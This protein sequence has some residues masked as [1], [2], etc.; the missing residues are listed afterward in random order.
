[1]AR[2]KLAA[3]VPEFLEVEVRRAL[4]GLDAERRVAALAGDA[5]DLVRQLHGFRQ[6]EEGLGVDDGGVDPPLVET[7]VANHREAVAGERAA[8]RGGEGVE[9]LAVELERDRR[10]GACDDGFAQGPAS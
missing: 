6:G 10:D 4:G 9:I 1:M 5:R 2:G 7:V 3:D 8:E